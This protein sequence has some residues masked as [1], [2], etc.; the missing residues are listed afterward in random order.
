VKFLFALFRGNECDAGP[1]KI[2]AGSLGIGFWWG[3]KGEQKGVLLFLVFAIKRE[4]FPKIL[5]DSLKKLVV[6]LLK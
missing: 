1:E 4:A 5:V 6:T 2:S 3:F